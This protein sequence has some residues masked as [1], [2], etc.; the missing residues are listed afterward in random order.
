MS[1]RPPARRA[2]RL[3]RPGRA[4]LLRELRRR[5][6]TLARIALWSLA[7]SVPALLSGLLISAALDRFLARDVT[8][9]V[10]ALTLLLV[11]AAAGAVATYRVLPMLAAIVEPVRDAFVTAVV[12]GAIATSVRSASR[13]DAAR[14]AQ[15]T[16]QVHTVRNIL[17][18]LMRSARQVVFTSLAALI[19][20]ALIAPLA[21]LVTGA[22]MGVSLTLFALL[23]RRLV[24]RQRAVLLAEEEVARRGGE[25]FG[26][27]RDAIACAAE[28]R[29]AEEVGHAVQAEAA[30]TRELARTTVL[31]SPL[32]F[33]GGQLPLVVLLA[34][35]PWLL[36][37]GHLTVAE[38]VGAAT[39]LT[40]RIEPALRGLFGTMGAW[41]IELVVTLDRLGEGFAEPDPLP[42]ETTSEPS[43]YDLR[44]RDLT[45]A[46]GPHAAAIFRSLDLTVPEGEHIAV[47]GPSGIGKSTLSS[48]LIGLLSPQHGSVH[49]GGVDVQGRARDLRR[50]LALIP[51]EAYIFAGTLRDNLTYLA[52]DA[53]DRDVA[54]AEPAVRPDPPYGRFGAAR[55]R[56][57]EVRRAP[58]PA[59]AVPEKVH[60]VPGPSRS[61]NPRPGVLSPRPWR[62]R[63][64]NLAEARALLFEGMEIAQRCHASPLVKA[65][66]SE[67]A[68]AGTRPRRAY[69][70]GP[71]SLTPSEVRVV[72][73]AAEGLT[74][75]QIAQRLYVTIKTVEVH[76]SNAYHKLGVR[77]R[78]QLRDKLATSNG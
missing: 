53:T 16:E 73:L 27:L 70:T 60:R 18:A 22:L 4:L 62:R 59:E 23:L 30:V 12:E 61:R 68:A 78:H 24:G 21:A 56:R 71:E 2:R 6:G 67:L 5:R 57:R 3:N 63:S 40:V 26:G 11:A 34:A 55:S 48:L 46:H 19:G 39:Y 58:S 43:R 32:V 33:L 64:G 41:G 7:E 9:G 25:V 28:D 13:P 36:R 76:L 17:F 10:A 38:L 1:A 65:A 66:R 49:L 72:G 50:V 47:V 42:E 35:A 14:V 20:L 74:N 75:S 29:A 31:R 54:H 15:L 69:L 37:G 44:I 8:A 52:P 45:F 77:R 51:Q